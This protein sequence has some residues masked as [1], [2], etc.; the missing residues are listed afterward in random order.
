MPNL[1]S[2]AIFISPKRAACYSADLVTRQY[3]ITQGQ[4]K[5][6]INYDIIQPVYTII[7]FEKSPREFKQTKKCKHFFKI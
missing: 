4:A 6:E 1:L 2:D 5:S 3:A 7:I